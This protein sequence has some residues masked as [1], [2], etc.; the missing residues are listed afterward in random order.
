MTGFTVFNDEV[1]FATRPLS[2]VDGSVIDL[3]ISRASRNARKRCRM[4]FH[5]APDAPFHDMLIVHGAEAFVPAH[6]HF[7][8]SETLHVVSGRAL[9]AVFDNDG[10]MTDACEMSRDAVFH[11]HMPPDTYHSLLI[12]SDWFVFQESTTGPFDATDSGTAPWSPDENN[13]S[14]VASARNDWRARA[15]TLITSRSAK[16]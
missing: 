2:L 3:L 12:E 8:R 7:T 14:A 15:E 11:Y 16:S 5:A 10:N 13:M 6:K 1:L 9:A 4:C